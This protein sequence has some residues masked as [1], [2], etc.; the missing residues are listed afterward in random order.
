MNAL[1]V[2][3]LERLG[4]FLR[5]D[6]PATRLDMSQWATGDLGECGT[7]GCALG[8]ATQLWPNDLHLERVGRA[9]DRYDVVCYP[10][11]RDPQVGTNAAQ[12]FFGLDYKTTC[13]LFSGSDFGDLDP[14]EEKAEVIRRIFEVVK[15]YDN[16]AL[17]EMWADEHEE[18]TDDEILEEEII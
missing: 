18:P 16:E 4:Q 7:T 14:D 12:E 15:D 2:N 1:Q 17:D 13:Y 11:G 6:I 3:K 9:F 8:W 10:E 5:D